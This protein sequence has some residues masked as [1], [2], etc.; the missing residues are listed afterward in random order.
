MIGA[1]CEHYVQCAQGRE[2]KENMALDNHSHEARVRDYLS[3]LPQYIY[4]HHFLSRLAFHITRI[5]YAP[6][7]KPL[8]KW[9]A[10]RYRVD[11]QDAIDADIAAY[12]DFNSFFT[13]ALRP[14]TRPLPADPAAIVSPVDGDISQLGQL[15]RDRL[16]QAK[17]RRYRL[18]DLLGKRQWWCETLMGGSFITIYLAPRDYHRVHMPIGGKVVETFHVPGRLFSVNPSTTRVV[19]SLFTRNERVVTLFETAT[20]P[21][22]LILVGALLVGSIETVWPGAVTPTSSRWRRLQHHSKKQEHPL[23]LARGAEVARFNM[24]STVIVLF[25]AGVVEWDPHLAVGG[26]VVVGQRIGN[27]LSLG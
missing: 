20:A 22:A 10:R 25:P 18:D 24:G 19:N 15:E 14:G 27:M 2:N 8:I 13:R 17:G 11:L 4:P 26:R 3:V 16:L 7:R 12:P 23:A 1:D 21:F 9:F 5:R 6:F